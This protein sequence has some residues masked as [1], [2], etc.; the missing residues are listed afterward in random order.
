MMHKCKTEPAKKIKKI[1]YLLEKIT[2]KTYHW[3]IEPKIY[4][5]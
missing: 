1:D 4:F 2:D 3:L 5:T